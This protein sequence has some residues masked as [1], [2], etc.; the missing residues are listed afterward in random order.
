MS[1]LGVAVNAMSGVFA[2]I[3][4]DDLD[5]VEQYS[6][7]FLLDDR[8]ASLLTSLDPRKIARGKFVLK[9][10]SVTSPLAR[11]SGKIRCDD[12]WDVLQLDD[13]WTA[14]KAVEQSTVAFAGGE[15]LIPCYEVALSQ[16]LQ[17]ASP[18]GDESTLQNIFALGFSSKSGAYAGPACRL[19]GTQGAYTLVT[20][21]RYRK[22]TG[23][24]APS[25]PSFNLNSVINAIGKA[26]IIIESVARTVSSVVEAIASDST[27][28]GRRRRRIDADS[29][30]QTHS[31][32]VVPQ[33]DLT[34]RTIGQKW[35]LVTKYY[36]INYPHYNAAR[37]EVCETF[38][39]NEASPGK[40][41][42]LLNVSFTGPVTFS[43]I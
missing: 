20:F 21:V 10:A 26:R 36:E 4:G 31:T 24:N 3:V 11:F 41:V 25:D 38:Y 43:G 28:A 13:F 35:D 40:N 5:P 18:P 1:F 16:F 23:T 30:I 22:L 17:N 37:P 8:D 34:T 15:R 32:T 2:R 6:C 33:G 7:I 42:S 9:V 39:F 12:N 14:R 27:S 19:A 29:N